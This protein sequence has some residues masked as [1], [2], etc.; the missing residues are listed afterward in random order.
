MHYG[1]E[2]FTKEDE[3]QYLSWQLYSAKA[4]IIRFIIENKVPI[5]KVKLLASD[6]YNEYLRQK[7][8]TGITYKEFIEQ[9][10]NL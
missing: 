9:Y 1:F 7:F 10:N 5:K 8:K 3:L 4:Q 2:R 6:L